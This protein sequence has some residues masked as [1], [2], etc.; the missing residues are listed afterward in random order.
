VTLVRRPLLRFVLFLAVTVPLTAWIGATILGVDLGDRYQLRASFTDVAG[1]FDGDV[2]K[3]AGVEVGEVTGIDV[4]RGLAI[5]TF[6]VDEDVAL[7]DDTTVA[8][9]W[10]N[11]IG[12]RYLSLEPGTSTTMVA[13]GDTLDRSRNVVDLGQLVNQLAPLARA[14]SPDDL[15]RILTTLV[16]AFEGNDANFDALFADMTAVLETL[17]ARDSTID[18]MLSDYATVA[19]AVADRDAQI[20]AM[21]SNLASIS[22]TFA[23]NDAL[24]DQALVELAT[25]SD[26]LDRLFTQTGDDLGGVL[27]SLAVLTGTAADRVDQLEAALQGLPGTFAALLPAV[28]R[29]E[30]LRVNVLCVVLQPGPCNHPIGALPPEQGEGGG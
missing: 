18:Q 3:L 2:V 7:P 10:R 15:N 1:L 6:E 21:V 27:D 17:A 16:E 9:R 29:G 12:Q 19:G 25:F 8:V 5:V 13:D 26:G 20:Q 28:N 14:V 23:D 22:E 11:L 30:W 4:E 24:L